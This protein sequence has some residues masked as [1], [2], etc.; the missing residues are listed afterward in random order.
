M[1][2]VERHDVLVGEP[3]S[4]APILITEKEVVFDTAA[5]VPARPTKKRGSREATGAV[6]AQPR[7]HYPRR[8]VF[9]ENSCIAREM[10]RL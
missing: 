8:Y 3:V 4:P 1:T 6:L 2:T 7:Q 9:L 5:A 10:H